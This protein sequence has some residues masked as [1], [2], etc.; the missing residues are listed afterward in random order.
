MIWIFIIFLL[1]QII[2]YPLVGFKLIR[3]LFKKDKTNAKRNSIWLIGLFVFSG[4]VFEILPGSKLLWWPIEAIESKSYTKNLMGIS[5]ILP[6]PIYELNSERHFNGDG[7]SFSVYKLDEKIIEELINPDSTFFNQYPKRGIR[8]DWELKEWNRTPLKTDD[9]D[10][11]HFASYAENK[12]EY[13]LEELL[14]EKGNYYAFKYYKHLFS[15]GSDQILNVDFYLI[16]PKRNILICV[17]VN[18]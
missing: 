9:K 3:A 10:A 4:L 5:F 1:I 7:S 13:N 16:S 2:G 15:S 11:F 6:Q 18:T 8:D 17:N 14:N 12:S